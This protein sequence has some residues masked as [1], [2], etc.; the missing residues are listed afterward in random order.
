[1]GTGEAC[2]LHFQ[3]NDVL[4]VIMTIYAYLLVEVTRNISIVSTQY[5][6]WISY[7]Y[8]E[9]KHEDRWLNFQNMG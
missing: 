6:W 1:M 4:I 5:T 8:F 7:I 2:P 3:Y 9:V